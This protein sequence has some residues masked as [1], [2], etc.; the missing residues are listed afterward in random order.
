MYLDYIVFFIR[1]FIF[2]LFCLIGEELVLGVFVEGFFGGF[3]GFEGFIWGVCL[4]FLVRFFSF[5]VCVCNIV[6]CFGLNRNKMI[7][8]L[9]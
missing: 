1:I 5:L 7:L 2:I 3:V 6:F 8:I 9:F 4:N